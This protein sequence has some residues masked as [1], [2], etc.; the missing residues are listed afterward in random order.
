MEQMEQNKSKIHSMMS[1]PWYE[2]V[3]ERIDGYVVSST[4]R[5]ATSEEIEQAKALHKQGKCPHTIVIDVYSWMHDFRCCFTCGKGL[6]T[7]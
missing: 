5:A 2:E 4:I 7:V 6:G 1:G 3:I